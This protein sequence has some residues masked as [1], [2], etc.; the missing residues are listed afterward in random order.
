M[1]IPPRASGDTPR[2][3]PCLIEA[4]AKLDTMRLRS[5]EER[6]QLVTAS[7][8]ASDFSAYGLVFYG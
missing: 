5:D 6:K 3:I 4:P 7:R 1:N 8:P 2:G